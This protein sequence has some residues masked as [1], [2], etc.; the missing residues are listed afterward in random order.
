MRL[1]FVAI[2]IASVISL[3]LSGQPTAE[4]ISRYPHREAEA[5][6]RAVLDEIFRSATSPRHIVVVD[7]LIHAVARID[8]LIPGSPGYPQGFDIAAL[9]NFARVTSTPFG[10]R[11]T[12][13]FARA[14]FPRFT[15]SVPITRVSGDVLNALSVSRHADT[16]LVVR[17]GWDPVLIEEHPFWTAFRK[18]FPRAWGYTVL[19]RVGFDDGATNAFVQVMHRCYTDCTSIESVF[20]SKSG[21]RWRVLNRV[22][23]EDSREGHPPGALRYVGKGGRMRARALR[24]ADSTRLVVVDSIAMEKLPRHIRGKV[25][26]AMTGRGADGIPVYSLA[27]GG[28]PTKVAV[29]RNGQFHLRPATGGVLLVLQCPN[30][31]YDEARNLDGTS[32]PVPAGLDTTILMTIATFEPCW[33]PRR[34]RPIES[35]V[36]ESQAFVSSAFPSADE[37]QVY[38]ALIRTV[39]QD[40]ARTLLRS[41]SISR[42]R[43]YDR[44]CAGNSSLNVLLREGLV[45]STAIAD[46]RD[47]SNRAEPVNP[48]FA[49]ERGIQIITPDQEDYMVAE[50]SAANRARGSVEA[51]S[52]WSAIDEAF[53]GTTGIVSFTRVGFSRAGNQALVSVR[54]E[55]PGMPDHDETFLMT[56]DGGAWVVSQR[57]VERTPVT[58]GIVN[59]ACVAMRGGRK[60]SREE[61]AGVR[62][63]YRVTFVDSDGATHR[64]EIDIGNPGTGFTSGWRG[65]VLEV[66]DA[67]DGNVVGTWFSFGR[68]S[69]DDDAPSVLAPGGHF[70]GYKI[71]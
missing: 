16:V 3:P 56:R 70:C 7:S 49:R 58:A 10:P 50:A 55:R 12:S 5:V 26:N 24:L 66:R 47:K 44:R 39:T 41:H 6:Y 28:T 71:R 62:G 33:N 15:Y 19:T 60:F 17:D 9:R 37:A 63:T 29:T 25:V 30:A 42:C 2:L 67:S 36:L 4:E 22:H 52:L 65:P 8:S 61:L 53:P 64:E 23:G 45:D 27:W 31:P 48:A 1:P 51:P 40:T 35:G 13:E 68:V 11:R 34:I 32:F 57:D 46:Y 43:L 38:D 14:P 20:L 54:R 21:G 59:D 18:R 69:D